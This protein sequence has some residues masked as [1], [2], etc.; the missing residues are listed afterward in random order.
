M[1]GSLLSQWDTRAGDPCGS[2][3]SEAAG[4]LL[5]MGGK[6]A[7]A[8]AAAAHKSILPANLMWEFCVGYIVRRASGVHLWAI[9]QAKSCVS[10]SQG[11]G[12]PQ[13]VGVPLNDLGNG[14][15]T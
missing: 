12:V 5:Q 8:A 7:T 10:L 14:T 1:P 6:D 2:Q 13:G 4:V 11:L 9:S 15:L 3:G